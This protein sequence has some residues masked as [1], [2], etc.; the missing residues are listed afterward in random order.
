MSLALNPAQQA[1]VRH[2]GGPLLVL[3]GAGSGKT[4]VLTARIAYLIQER[5]VAPQRIFAVTFTNKAAG[6]MRARV[7]A[8]LGADPK[9]LWIGTFHSLSARLLRREAALL[10]FGPN[11]TIYDQDDSESFIKR[12]LEQRGL[13]PKANPPRAIHAMISGA[14]NRMLLPEELGAQA[15]SPL[16]RVAAEIYATLGPALRQANAMDFDDLLLHPLTLFREHPERLAYWQR[17]FEHVLVDEFQDTNSAQYRLVKL[18]AAQHTNLCVVGDDDQAIYGWRGADVRHMLSFQQDFPGASLIKLEQNYRSTQVILD[19]ANGVIAGNA[20]RL[21]KTLFTARP[22]GEPVTL[23]AA[24][25]ERD[26]AEWLAAELARR[27]AGADV[28]YEGM[29]I[30][31]RTNAQS[32]PLEEAFRFR[33]I[34][35]RLV[36]AVSF[37]ER[38]EVKDVLAYLRLIANPADDEAFVRI[39]NVPRRGIGDASLSQLLRAAA[40][41]GRPLLE[42]ARAAERISDLRPN[43]REAFQALAR[44]LDELRGR[45]GAADPATALE[46][47]IA[48]VGYGQYLADEGPEGIERLENVQ[49]LIAG[50]EAWA[51]TAVEEGEE[52]GN[53]AGDE[54]GEGGRVKG[55]TLIERY[56][57]QAALVTS[58][59]QGTGDPTGVTLM[60]VHMAKGLEWPVV[61]LAGL[62]DGLFPLARAAGEPGG[63]EEERRLCYVGLTRARE[64]LY[65]SWARTRYRNG[66]LELSESSRFLEALPPSVVEERGTA[67]QWD[68]ARRSG[69]SGAG[70]T[71]RPAPAA[72][73]WEE[74][75]SQDAPRYIA[76]ERVR[77]R[78]FGSGVVR[79]VSG[80]GREL[81]VIVEFDDSEIGT[82]QLLVAYA[83]LERE[84]E[85][86]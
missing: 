60:T 71:R 15:E 34:P 23:L 37:Y 39:V 52:A 4:R 50:A 54:A 18:L 59:D 19:A 84:W 28:P 62:E 81:K 55:A 56:L 24:A 85:S 16:Q 6:E 31:Y 79:A 51:E 86:A 9:G 1:A 49:E 22:G 83:G 25:D 21:G 64:K 35:Y 7:A 72:I 3:A 61:T 57:T 65:L 13:S 41:W 74:E 58:A 27:A 67:P 48:A 63:L 36:G 80:A 40:Q 14:K 73:E 26:E 12:L 75:A 47:V 70:G 42:T 69:G 43:V 78:K 46:Q 33:G 45:L 66:R 10:G 8:L 5:G 44:L 82:K 29:A 53:E 38:R 76:G 2:P 17:R 68:R 77:H 11:F 30:L 20:R 32:R